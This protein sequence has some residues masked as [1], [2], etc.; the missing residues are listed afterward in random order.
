M[1]TPPPPQFPAA[2]VPARKSSRGVLVAGAALVVLAVAAAVGV[3]VM[4]LAPGR[5][6]DARA[7]MGTEITVTLPDDDVRTLYTTHETWGDFTCDVQ[8]GAG[9]EVQLRPD[10]TSLPLPGSTTWYPRGGILATGEVTVRCDGDAGEFAVGPTLAF[11]DV[12][13]IY[14]VGWLGGTLGVTGILCLVVG[15]ARRAGVRGA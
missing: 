10:M 4:V 11:V 9:A 7:P 2:Q 15:V 5:Q 6:L 13:R 3:A 14:L 1:T 8:D 12:W